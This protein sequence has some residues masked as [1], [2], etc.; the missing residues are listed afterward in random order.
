MVKNFSDCTRF[1]DGGDD[2][3]GS[4]AM[5]TMLDVNIEHPFEQAC[6]TD[7]HRSR[8]CGALSSVS[9][10]LFLF[11]LLSGIISGRSLAFG[12]STPGSK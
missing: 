5:R 2:F 3:Q 1:Q 4:T 8:E 10:W 9:N 11:F 12:A 6:P 7:A